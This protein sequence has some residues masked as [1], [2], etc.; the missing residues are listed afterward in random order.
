MTSP[1]AVLDV[2]I[3][4]HIVWINLDNNLNGCEVTV[5][6]STTVNYNATEVMH[7]VT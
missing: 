1:K 2:P 3:N 7:L 5:V 6:D 4:N